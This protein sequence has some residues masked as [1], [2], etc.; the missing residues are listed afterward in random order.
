MTQPTRPA[1]HI[2]G[3]APYPSVDM[4]D[5]PPRISLAMNESPYPPSPDAVTAAAQAMAGRAKLYSDGDWHDLRAAISTVHGIDPVNLYCGAG[6]MDL[7]ACLMRAFISAGDSVLSTQYAYAYFKTATERTSGRY[8]VVAEDGFTV[9]VDA[10]LGAV[11]DAT[12]MVCVANPGNPTGTRIATSDLQR[13]RDGLAEDILLM[14][15]EAYGDFADGLDASTFDM[16]LRGNTV[17]LRTF[18]KVYALAGMRVGW[19]VFPTAIAG[20]MR[21]VQD[22]GNV[23]CVGLAAAAAAMRDQAYMKDVRAK[24]IETR[25]GFSKQLAQLGFDVPASFTNFV[26]IPFANSETA[27]RADSY[28]RHAGVVLRGMGLYGLPHCLRATIGTPEQ[29]DDVIALLDAWMKKEKAA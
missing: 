17:V 19:G 10:I 24:T 4:G 12:K 21:K 28:L 27:V 26:L 8:V 5:K 7:I 29:M 13:L 20:E 16:P 14:I 9:S 6:S 23:T 2:A 3:M 15:D 22:P 11:N 18:S 1:T 25:E